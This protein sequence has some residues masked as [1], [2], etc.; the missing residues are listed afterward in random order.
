M[1]R[2]HMEMWTAAQ[3]GML[4]TINCNCGSPRHATDFRTLLV[5]DLG[6]KDLEGELAFVEERRYNPRLGEG[7]DG[8]T[9]SY[10]DYE[11]PA[12]D[13][14]PQLGESL[15]ESSDCEHTVMV[16]PASFTIV[17]SA[18]MGMPVGI[19]MPQ[20]KR[21]SEMRCGCSSLMLHSIASDWSAFSGDA[22]C[23]DT[24]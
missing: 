17:Q 21:E 8:D 15:S 1:A 22:M 11:A 4:R 13:D 24:T 20:T 12:L 9:I 3:I 2:K 19:P 6:N 16:S 10:C 7:V 5:F 23:A 14:D 18:R